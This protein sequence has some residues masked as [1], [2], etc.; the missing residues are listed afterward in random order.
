MPN[1]DL[2]RAKCHNRPVTTPFQPPNQQP[3]PSPDEPR[4]APS[5]GPQ[6]PTAD[7]WSGPERAARTV[8]REIEAHVA[9]AGWDAAPRLFALVRTADAL[10]RDPALATQ[11]PVEVVQT[12]RADA[13]HLTAVEQEDLPVA[14]GLEDLLARIAWPETVDGAALVVERVVLPPQAEN[15]VM[16]EARALGLDTPAV[17]ER[18]AARPE[19]SDVRVAVAV[20]RDGTA[21]CALRQREHDSDALVAVA[22]DLVPTLVAA[23]RATFA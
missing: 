5:A 13:D 19:R 21:M 11:L 22:P 17:I 23:L 1:R 12:A 18:L 9:A 10:R 14:D 15:E 6:A 20:L 16:A 4:P 2:R 8:V 7:T 3:N